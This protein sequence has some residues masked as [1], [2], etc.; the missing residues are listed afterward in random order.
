MLHSFNSINLYKTCPFSYHLKY[1]LHQ[2][3]EFYEYK[4]I[5]GIV[6]HK[7][8]EQHFAKDYKL[9][10]E[11]EYFEYTFR[12]KKYYIEQNLLGLQ[13]HD[14]KEIFFNF[15]TVIE[16]DIFKKIENLEYKNILVEKKL[17]NDK[18][19]GNLD[20]L[21]FLNDNKV[22]L[23]D[24]KSGNSLYHNFE[25]LY[26]YATLI[27]ENYLEV[28]EILLMC[29][30][31]N[32]D[33]VVKNLFNRSEFQFY[34]NKF[35][36]EII[37]IEEDKSFNK[38][39]SSCK[40]CFFKKGCELEDYINNIKINITKQP[41]YQNYGDIF[42]CD[43]NYNS[44]KIILMEKPNLLTIKNKNT[45]TL[46]FDKVKKGNYFILYT[47]FFL[48]E[49]NVLK[50]VFKE[51]VI[52]IIKKINPKELYIIGENAY[53]TI[54]GTDTKID[55]LINKNFNISFD[56]NENIISTKV[57]YDEKKFIYNKEINTNYF[58]ENLI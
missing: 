43:G 48:D 31:F 11:I 38:N 25:Q 14:I 50:D 56:N 2:K 32:E 39:L 54:T 1:N 35:N 51:N 28:Q 29:Y 10:E 53:Q 46:I 44:N 9:I 27:F 4:T 58:K 55:F 37:Q 57:L 52:E 6:L 17:F 7:F 8:L 30:Y 20:L 19:V 40:R 41:K 26:I 45:T 24:Y 13:E 33:K 12:D 16:K 34:K 49:K 21:I 23:I 15:I 18:M 47:N 36:K 3:I 5:I 42:I 22:L